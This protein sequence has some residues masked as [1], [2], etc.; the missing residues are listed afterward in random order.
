MKKEKLFI[1]FSGGRSSAVMTNLC[2]QKY[3][4]THDI[5]VLFANTGLEHPNTL[6][7]VD[8]CDKF[9]GW[10]VIWIEAMFSLDEGTGVEPRV[11]TYETCSKHGEPFHWFIKK[12][13]LPNMSNPSC[14][15]RMKEIPMHKYIREVVGWKNGDYFTSI[16]LRADE[17]DRV[18]VFHKQKKFIYPLL[19]MGIRKDMVKLEMQSWAFDLD[20]P[21]DAYG[22]C[23]TC[24]KK[25]ER[26]LRTLAL[27]APEHFSFLRMMEQQYAYHKPTKKMIRM[28]QKRKVFR[29]YKST[30]NYIEEKLPPKF[31]PYR[32]DLF[33]QSDLFDPLIDHSIGCGDSCEIGHN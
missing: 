33:L 31:K 17:M 2:F 11:V 28:R 5:V 7:F 3:R 16:G 10:G 1:S 20:L 25:S 15:N 22:N 29:N 13:G 19:D 24:F 30:K 21:S 8:Q 4:D 23:I 12:N 9:Y 26:K 27:E 14:T 32:D 18:D 6:S